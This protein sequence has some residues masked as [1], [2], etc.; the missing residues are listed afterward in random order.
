MADVG[1]IKITTNPRGRERE[2]KAGVR[3]RE[4]PSTSSVAD[5]FDLHHFPV[6]ERASMQVL[7]EKVRKKLKHWQ[8]LGPE[9]NPHDAAEMMRGLQ[10]CAAVCE[11]M[12]RYADWSARSTGKVHERLFGYSQFAPKGSRTVVTCTKSLVS[13]SHIA[14]TFTPSHCNPRQDGSGIPLREVMTRAEMK[15]SVLCR[16]YANNT[17]TRGAR[18]RFAHR[19]DMMVDWPIPPTT[20]LRHLASG[21]SGSSTDSV[22]NMARTT[23]SGSSSVFA[24]GSSGSQAS[25]VY[26]TGE[27][28]EQKKQDEDDLL[29][30]TTYLAHVVGRTEGAIKPRLFAIKAG[31]LVAGYE[32]PM[33][34]RVRIWAALSGYKRWRPATKKKYPVLPS[35]LLWVRQRLTTSQTYSRADQLIIWAALMVGFF[36]LLRASEYLVTLG[37]SWGSTRTLRGCDVEG[38]LENDKQVNNLH[39]AEEIVTYLNGSK[40][41]QLNQGTARNQFKSGHRTLCVVTALA[42]YQNLKPERF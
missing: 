14:F 15:N 1:R 18:C 33:L 9:Q 23:E 34:H 2:S 21:E 19:L 4:I 13:F 25:S 8:V 17:C 28:Q 12:P 27:T 37:R 7:T 29:R 32:D 16:Y 42:E 20:R 30:F 40:T 6:E 39:H 5:F 38:C 3:V 35:M 22:A 41:D 26:L 24:Q 10:T 31:H 36:F 11:R